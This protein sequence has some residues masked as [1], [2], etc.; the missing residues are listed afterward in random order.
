MHIFELDMR[1]WRLSLFLKNPIISSHNQA[2]LLYILFWNNKKPKHR[3]STLQDCSAAYANFH[4]SYKFSYRTNLKYERQKNPL[5]FNNI[6]IAK[7]YCKPTFILVWENFTRF[8]RTSLSSWTSC[9]YL[10]YYCKLLCFLLASPYIITIPPFSHSVQW[11]YIVTV[12]Y[13]EIVHA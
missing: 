8:G 4:A 11:F 6:S 12:H 13:A 3:I 2:G 5:H 1:P 7:E 9:N 10:S